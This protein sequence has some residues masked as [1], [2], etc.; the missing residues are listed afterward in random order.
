[1]QKT[2][3]I[4]FGCYSAEITFDY[5]PKQVSVIIKEPIIDEVLES[6]NAQDIKNY[7][8]EHFKVG[9]IFSEKDLNEWASDNGYEKE[10]SVK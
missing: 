8:L 7:V 2:K 4:T 1:M 5:A 3:E 9:E 10:A 6:M